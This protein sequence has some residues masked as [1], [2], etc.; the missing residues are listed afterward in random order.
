MSGKAFI[1]FGGTCAILAGIVGL[2]YSVAFLVSA[3]SSDPQLVKTG[4]MLA[5]LFLVI[6][7]LLSSAVMA[8]LYDQLKEGEGGFA[9]WALVLGAVGAAGSAIHGAY[10]LA[11][12]INPPTAN[13]PN[14]ADLP[15]QVDPRGF[16]TFGAVGLAVLVFSWLIVRGGKMPKNVGNLGIVLGILLVVIYLARL[17]ILDASNP[18]VVV[19]VVVTGFIVNPVWNIWLGVNLRRVGS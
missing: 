14:L 19:T 18:I 2:L 11:N 6:G 13:V 3:R 4:G 15:S 17:I 16:L 10:D 12:A 1:R 8:A 7:G 9:L 5:A